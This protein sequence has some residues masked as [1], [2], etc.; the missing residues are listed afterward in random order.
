MKNPLDSEQGEGMLVRFVEHP[1]I[2]LQSIKNEI[3]AQKK[4]S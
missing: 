4:G 1:L 2:F 3:S